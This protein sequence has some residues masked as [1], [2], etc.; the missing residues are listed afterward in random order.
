ML[1]FSQSLVVPQSCQS[2]VVPQFCVN[3]GQVSSR[4]LLKDVAEI[5]STTEG[6]RDV[7]TQSEASP[8]DS[9]KSRTRPAG[10]VPEPSPGAGATA[11]CT[12]LRGWCRGGQADEADFLQWQRQMAVDRSRGHFFKGLY[13]SQADQDAAGS[14]P[15][16]MPVRLRNSLS[17]FQI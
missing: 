7:T 1:Q 16:R 9:H 17:S 2:L 6:R 11:R 4:M 3:I 5:A 8:S 14:Y 12:W 10:A 13:T 15:R